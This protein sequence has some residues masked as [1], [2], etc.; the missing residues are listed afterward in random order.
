[1]QSQPNIVHHIIFVLGMLYSVLDL[2]NFVLEILEVFGDCT[3]MIGGQKQHP[4]VWLLMRC[5][6]FTLPARFLLREFLATELMEF[7][8]LQ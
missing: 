5:F 6:F 1:M 4:G 3:G 7:N 2:V 8:P